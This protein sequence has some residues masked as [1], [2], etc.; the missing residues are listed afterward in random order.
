MKTYY[1]LN[2]SELQDIISLINNFITKQSICCE[3]AVFEDRVYENAPYLI[4]NIC[5]IL[6]YNE[7][8]EEI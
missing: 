6:G 8:E 1:E 5:D 4:G 7:S 3:E 2:E